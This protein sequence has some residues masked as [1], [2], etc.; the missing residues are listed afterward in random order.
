MTC[1]GKFI[2][3]INENG[4]NGREPEDLEM[5]FM[6]PTHGFS[7][8]YFSDLRNAIFEIFMNVCRK[9][10]GKARQVLRGAVRKQFSF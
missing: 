7:N 1:L 9:L 2:V 8:P 5:K 3:C 10:R 6:Y 4:R